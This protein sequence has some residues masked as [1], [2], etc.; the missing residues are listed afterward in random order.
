VRN[1]LLALA[2]FVATV[3]G[4]NAS[5]IIDIGG[6]GVPTGSISQT[7]WDGVHWSMSDT[8]TN[9]SISVGLSTLFAASGVAYLTTQLGPGTTVADEVASTAFTFP[10]GSPSTVNLFSGLTLGPGDYYLTLTTEASRDLN[11]AWEGGVGGTLA[12]G[13]VDLGSYYWST[14]GGSPLSSLW[15]YPPTMLSS[16]LGSRLAYS[17]DGDLAAPVPEPAS[18]LLLGTGLAGLVLRR[19]RRA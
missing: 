7:Q 1:A 10:T 6:N 9:V 17:V 5:P 2:L 8:Y 15:P 4:A 3:S 16:G 14:G 11:P 19:R 12:P 18:M 13:V